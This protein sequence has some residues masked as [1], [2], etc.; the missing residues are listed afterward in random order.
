MTFVEKYG[1]CKSWS[2]K[3]I[4]MRLYHLTAIELNKG[5]TISQTAS[6]FNVSVGLVSENLR[7][8]D[9]IDR[10]PSIQNIKTRQ[11]ALRKL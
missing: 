5:W 1:Q 7:L 10:N 11:E 9:L 6:V 3:V 4:V 2:D 8:A